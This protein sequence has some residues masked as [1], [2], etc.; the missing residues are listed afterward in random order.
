M[1]AVIVTTSQS[2]GLS[3]DP[4]CEITGAVETLIVGL[5][6]AQRNSCIAAQSATDR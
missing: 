5:L 2:S 4:K 3:S 1:K 6:R